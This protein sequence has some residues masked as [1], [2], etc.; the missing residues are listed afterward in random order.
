MKGV[1]IWTLDSYFNHCYVKPLKPSSRPGSRHHANSCHGLF[2]YA[3][4]IQPNCPTQPQAL[5]RPH[6]WLSSLTVIFDSH[7]WNINCYQ[8]CLK[9]LEDNVTI[10][11]SSCPAGWT[12][13]LASRRADPGPHP[14]YLHKAAPPPS[15]FPLPLAPSLRQTSTQI[16]FADFKYLQGC[17][18][19]GCCCSHSVWGRWFIRRTLCSFSST[20]TLISLIPLINKRLSVSVADKNKQ[21]RFRDFLIAVRESQIVEQIIFLAADFPWL[22]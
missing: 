15:S 16:L 22:I 5:W 19:G 3:D 7:L 10:H 1:K 20:L 9:S 13:T 21:D 8:S 2:C 17:R 18:G 4:D 14:R 6:P 12:S 11:P